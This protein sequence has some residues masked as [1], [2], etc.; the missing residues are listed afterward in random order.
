MAEQGKTREE[1]LEEIRVLR[2]KEALL[3]IVLDNL[4]IG[5]ALNSVDPEV[6]F[7]YMNDNFPA[8]YRTTRE[9]LVSPDA[10]WEAVYR[11]KEFRETIRKRVME[12]IA[13]GVPERMQWTDVPISL[14]GEEPVF[15]SAKNIPVPGAHL[16]VSTVQDTTERKI[17]EDRIKASEEYLDRII[18]VLGDPVFVKDSQHRFIL[19]NDAECALAG[20]SREEMLGKTDY[21]FFPKEQVDVFWAKDE[22]LLMTGKE[23]INEEEIT[24][25][26]G[27]K[28]TIVT[29]KNLFVDRQGNRFIVGIIRDITERKRLELESRERLRELEIYF[30]ASMGREERI[31][32][33]KQEVDRLKKR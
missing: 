23:N 11:D 14:K 28:R 6:R 5:I 32:E 27:N 19:V 1:M 31:I 26:E 3:Q 33:L 29:K 16:M 21:D 2:Q 13:S 20:R 18:N 8:I 9:K 25:A 4:P 12:D 7:E 22:A 17:A 24:D 30:K 15:I 10:F